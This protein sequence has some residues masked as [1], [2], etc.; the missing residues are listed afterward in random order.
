MP[1]SGQ[2]YRR[3][4]TSITL[5]M[6]EGDPKNTEMF[7]I[8]LFLFIIKDFIYSWMGDPQWFVVGLETLYSMWWRWHRKLLTKLEV[9]SAVP[10]WWED[11]W[12]IGNL[13]SCSIARGR[14]WER[15]RYTDK[16]CLFSRYKKIQKRILEVRQELGTINVSML[17]C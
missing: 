8:Y 9:V 2:G 15:F 4:L 17:T 16:Y 7:I 10:W 14:W 13:S 3:P 6:M 12:F 5:I 11:W 1:W